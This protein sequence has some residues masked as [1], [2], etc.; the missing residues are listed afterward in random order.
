MP[1]LAKVEHD[2]LKVL[3]EQ[4]QVRRHHK[5]DTLIRQ[6]EFG[7]SMYV[8]VRGQVTIHATDDKGDTHQVATLGKPGDFFGEVALLGRGARMATVICASDAMLVDRKSVV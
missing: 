2:A 7:H 8:L 5:G 1:F 6:G 3:A 4:S